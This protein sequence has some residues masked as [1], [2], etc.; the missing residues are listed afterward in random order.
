[1]SEE[2]LNDLDQEL[3][4]MKRMLSDPEAPAAEEIPTPEEIPVTEE[5]RESSESAGAEEPEAAA[6]EPARPPKKKSILRK[7]VYYAL[8]A[9]FIGVFIFCAVYIADY[10]V[11]SIKRNDLYTDLGAQIDQ[12]RGEN[13]STDPTRG[14]LPNGETLPEGDNNEL[15]GILPEYRDAYAMNNDMVGWITIPDTKI[16]YPV[17]QTPDHP[18]YYLYRGFDK[19]WNAGGSIYA[20]EQCDVFTP[21]DNIVLYGH[22]MADK[23]MF[24]YLEKYRSHSYWEEHQYITFDTIYER[25]TYQIIA[26][27]KTSA[28]PGQ[29]FSYHLFN[30]AKNEEEF[31]KFIETVHSL[32][33]Y[34]TG[35]TAEYGDM[36]LTLSTCE[37]TLDNGRLVVIAK[38]IS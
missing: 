32:E 1:M 2:R 27:F 13:S 25:H 20:R 11:D 30:T 8:L 10:M 14:T 37:Y 19:V 3:E 4:E 24:W 29:G 18:D 9:L 16:N 34:D 17:M 15:G 7:V 12:L 35:L 26:A 33:F 5:A 6:A 21:S 22:H 38:R 31:N 36:L 23:S 28:T